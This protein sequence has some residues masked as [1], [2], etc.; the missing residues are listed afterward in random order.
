[1]ISEPDILRKAKAILDEYGEDAL[2]YAARQADEL[3]ER[4]NV[5]SHE[6]WLEIVHVLESTSGGREYPRP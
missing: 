1:M 4:G 5:R 6:V 3:L 2:Y